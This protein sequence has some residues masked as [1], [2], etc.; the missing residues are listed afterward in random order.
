[1]TNNISQP[2]IPEEIKKNFE[3]LKNKLNKIKANLLKEFNKYILGIALLPPTKEQKEKKTIEILILVDDSDSKNVD[4]FA[5]KDR[6][7][8]AIEKSTKA[9]D[10]KILPNVVLKSEL[11]ESCYDGKYELLNLISLGAIIHDPTDMLAAIKISEVHKSMVLKKFD[12][13]IVSYV[14]AGSIFRGE[15]SNDIDVYIVIDD[16]DV[17]KMSRFELKD[18]LRAIIIS[19]GMQARDITGVKKE[20]HIQVYILT[21]FWESV[22]DASPVIFTFLRDGVPLFDRG[23]FMP[24]KLLLKMG[25]IRPSPEA[26]DMHMEVGE[27]SIEM[28]RNRLLSIVGQDIYY[29][30]LNPAQAALMLYGI[31]PPTP[32]EAIHLLNEIFVK[33][34]KLLEKKYVDILEK[35]RK[36]YKSIEHGKVKQL[37]GAEVDSMLKDA[38]LYMKRIKKL[39]S[40]I[41]KKAEA[42]T[43]T[44]IYENCTA[45]AKDVLKLEKINKSPELGF[46]E[47]TKKNIIPERFYGILKAVTK[48][49]QDYGKKNITKQEIEKV[50]RSANVFLGSMLDYI[51]RKRG[52]ELERAKIRFKHGDD[53]FGELYLLEDHAFII[54]NIDAKEKEV[55]KAKV[56]DGKL[57]NIKNSSLIELE[58]AITKKRIPKHVFI[59]EN[60]FEDLKKLYGKGIKISVNY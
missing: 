60:I 6:L 55:A 23:V 58:E 43:I 34:E 40:Q 39:F 31:A 44:E 56:V 45:I 5:L 51:Q 21:D 37:S 20:F 49:K 46:K 26:I 2:K 29:G 36:F 54:N 17:K 7:I 28:A 33:K 11:V 42:K 3:E 16:T 30:I 57:T 22:K 18:K 13:Y 12:K 50:R 14:A 52:L 25:R 53:T 8:L 10:E 1:M 9:I 47:L 41:E 32:T 35:I 27:K 4:R 48:A 15:K 24:W 19:M 59:H 38:D